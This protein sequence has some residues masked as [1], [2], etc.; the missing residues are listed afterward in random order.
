MSWKVL[1]TSRAIPDVGEEA[2]A[3]LRKHGCEVVLPPVLGPYK[4]DELLAKIDGCD[5]ALIS[6]DQFTARVFASPATNRL[7]LVSRWGVGY[8]SIDVAAA[9]NAGVVVTYTPG[10]LDETVADYT[11]ALLLSLARRVHEAH[12]KM[13]AGIWDLMW[14]TNVFGKTL[15]IVGCGRIGRAVAK[16]A[17]GFDMRVIA[18]DL[19]PNPEA[20]K[21]GI[22]FMGLADLLAESDFVSLHCALTPETKGFFNADVFGKM[23]RGALFVNTARGAMVDETALAAALREGRLGGAALDVFQ[24]EPLPAG[25]PFAGLSKVL[26]SPHQSSCTQETGR[27]VSLAAAQAIVDLM[28]GRR[29]ALVLNGA[30]FDS[31]K[32]RARIG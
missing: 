15:G 12:Q 18:H 14:G 28:E 4:E 23:K 27:R 25:N 24:Q 31:A 1:I 13:S 26:L 29:P 11:F 8:D 30:V 9:T 22:R 2:V 32:L 6:P 3:L 10:F 17:A 7:K 16:R 21:M 20:E 19:V 5:A